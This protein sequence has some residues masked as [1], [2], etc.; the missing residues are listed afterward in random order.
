MDAAAIVQI[1]LGRTYNRMEHI[2]AADLDRL[3]SQNVNCAES[4]AASIHHI[5]KLIN[6]VT[7]MQIIDFGA[8]MPC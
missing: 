5:D 1:G 2:A 3:R 8:E 6:I 7:R 4:G